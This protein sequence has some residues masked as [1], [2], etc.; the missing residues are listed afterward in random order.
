VYAS[1]VR[2]GNDTVTA[3]F[4][5]PIQSF[6]L[7]YVHEYSG[8]APSGALDGT[9]GASGTTGNMDSGPLTTTNPT[10][11]LFTG[12]A[13]D[14]SVTGIA[15]G[16][17]IRMTDRGNLTADSYQTAQ[18]QY[19]AAGTQSGGAWAIQ[20]VALRTAQ[21]GGQAPTNTSTPTATPTRTA[22]ST[23]TATPTPSPSATPT[24]TAT[25]T[26]R[27]TATPTNTPSS[28][29]NLV[30]PVKQ[31]ANG[32]YLVDQRG[33]PFLMAGDA[34]Q[35]LIG[36][37]SLSDAN[38]YF[39]DRQ[40]KGFNAV[41]INLLCDSYTYCNSD[42]TTFDGI[43]PFTTPGDLSTPNPTYFSKVD[44]VLQLAANHGLLVFL[45]PAETGGWFATLQ[46][47]GTAR[48]TAYGKFL[49][50]RYKNQPNIVWLSGNDYQNW[51][52][53]ADQYVGAVAQGIK[54]ADPN[55][56]HTVELN[57]TRSGS[58]DDPYWVPLIG[59]DSAYTYFPTYDEILNEYNRSTVMPVYLAEANYEF[60]NNTGNDPSTPEVLRQQLW[61]T[62]TSGGIGQLYG[63]HY[64]VTFTSGWQSNLDTT[65]AAQ[66]QLATTFLRGLAW[67]NLVPDQTH[68]MLTAGYGT[69]SSDGALHTN[70]YATA[71]Q[72]PDGKLGL[73]Y[74]PVAT[75]LTVNLATFS[76][77]VTAT[78]FDPTTGNT[79]AAGTYA[80]SKSQNFSVPGKHA[81]GGNDWVLVL[82]TG[83]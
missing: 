43:P 19:H 66:Q 1:N 63:N 81:D 67:Y 40:A 23:N 79:I 35:S 18:G 14:N 70:N 42:G 72:T 78:W 38:T 82:Q 29:G 5:A 75:T 60:E 27:A 76:G 2:A 61:W 13:S 24:P 74:A 41:W 16:Y 73:I 46:S 47:N 44:Q 58:Q 11:V 37:L 80:N 36:N 57:Y 28:S 25:S 39:A 59:L 32:R 55:H 52:T 56:L 9:S 8:L 49:G 10:D 34:P 54:S 68:K 83:P 48:D 71:A 53:S 51:G 12:A 31:S 62:M 64:T 3:T 45:D 6:A 4:S 26:P 17:T 65:G 33:T 50:N 69:Y 77:Q 21:G 7:I 15:A 22:V 30:Y 20:V